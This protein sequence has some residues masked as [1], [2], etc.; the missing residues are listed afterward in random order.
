MTEIRIAD[1]FSRFPGGRYREFGKFSG[2][3]FRE[4]FLIEALNGQ[5]TVKVII[6]GTAGYGSSFLEEAF[7]GLVRQGYRLDQLEGR[8]KI[9]ATDPD[10]ETYCD[11]IWQY[12]REAS[13]RVSPS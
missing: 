10:F 12:I 8:L 6:D 7:G 1:N 2:E 11:E 13:E 4:N 3:E 5:D 9:V